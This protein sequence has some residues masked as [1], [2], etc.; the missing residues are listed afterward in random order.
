LT[1]LKRTPLWEKLSRLETEIENAKGSRVLWID[2]HPHEVLSERR[3]FRALGIDVVTAS[4][5]TRADSILKEDNDFD[6]MISDVQRKEVKN[7]YDRY[8]GIYFIK[9]L[10]EKYKGS[11]GIEALP[12]IFYSAYT[13]AQLEIIKR[14]VGESFLEEM[15]FSGSFDTLL[16]EV[17]T[18]LARIRSSPVTVRPK[19]KATEVV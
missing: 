14:Q 18:T 3:V 5:S 16:P 12:V 13:P 15:K 10:R 2:D 9:E 7:E 1:Y 11:P 4:N 17:I 6:L 19:K 8:D